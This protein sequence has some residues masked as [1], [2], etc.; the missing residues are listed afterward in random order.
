M[1]LRIACDLDGTIA[2]M[3]AALQ[4][5]ARRLF[6]PDVDLHASSA[7]PIESAEDVEEELAAPSPSEGR[8]V[9][10]G[11]TAADPERAPQAV[12]AGSE[13]GGF[14]VL[15]RRDRAGR[16]RPLRGALGA[17]SLGRDLRDAAAFIGG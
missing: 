3:D 16:R 1:S 13:G 17:A 10:G 9:A 6:G 14:L 7:A 11:R 4:R 8:G 12:D 2:D 15:P 5:E